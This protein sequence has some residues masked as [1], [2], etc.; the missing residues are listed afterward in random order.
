MKCNK[1]KFRCAIKTFDVFVICAWTEVTLQDLLWHWIFAIKPIFRNLFDILCYCCY[2]FVKCGNGNWYQGKLENKVII[3]QNFLH[4]IFT[5]RH[6]AF[7]RH[8]GIRAFLKPHSYAYE[9]NVWCIKNQTNHSSKTL[10]RWVRFLLHQTLG[11]YRRNYECY[12]NTY[13]F[14]KSPLS[15]SNCKLRNKEYDLFLRTFLRQNQRLTI[16]TLTLKTNGKVK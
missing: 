5:C 14:F 9:F 1:F 7:E 4:P 3:Y 16:K 11:N 2:E 12:R 8:T 10:M 6:A 13:L 15:L